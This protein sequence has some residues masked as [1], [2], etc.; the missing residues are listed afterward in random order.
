MGDTLPGPAHL[1]AS[2]LAACVLKNVER[3]SHMLPFEYAGALVD[4]ELERQDK[5]PRI[6]RASYRLVVD[7]DEPTARCR[8]LHKNIAKFGTI[9]NTLALACALSGSM[10]ARRPSGDVED[11]LSP[12]EP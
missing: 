1:L 3:F 4:V 11:I 12:H 9:S 7:T 5:P 6:V 10:Q 8:L 2:A